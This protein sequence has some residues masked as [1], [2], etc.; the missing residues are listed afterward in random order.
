MQARREESKAPSAGGETWQ[1][2][3]LPAGSMNSEGTIPNR[4]HSY[5]VVAM[6]MVYAVTVPVPAPKLAC[7]RKGGRESCKFPRSLPAAAQWQS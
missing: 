1:Q 6:Q 7:K 5:T 4:V 3:G 2:L